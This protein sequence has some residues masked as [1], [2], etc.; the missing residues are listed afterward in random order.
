VGTNAVPKSF[1][2]GRLGQLVFE[3]KPMA[4]IEIYPAKLAEWA[5]AS[6][7]EK[8]T[9]VPPQNRQRLR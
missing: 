6:Y 8:H 2:V 5:T 7:V 4:K 9:P 1:C 3:F